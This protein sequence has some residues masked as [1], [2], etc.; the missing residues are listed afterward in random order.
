M[1]GFPASIHDHAPLGADTLREGALQEPRDLTY[2]EPFR[3]ERSVVHVPCE[4]KPRGACR[5]GWFI[6][7]GVGRR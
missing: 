2:N 7:I 4:G 5:R 1:S 6:V 3:P